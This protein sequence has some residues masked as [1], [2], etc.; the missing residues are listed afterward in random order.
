[1]HSRM[2]GAEVLG[3]EFATHRFAQVTVY[4]ARIDHVTV[5]LGVQVLEQVLT[6]Q[7]MTPPHDLHDALLI[8]DDLVPDTAF[9]SKLQDRASAAR[10]ADMPV[11]KR[12]DPETTVG[13]RIFGI[14]NARCR[15]TE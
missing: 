5:A 13:P 2:P 7:R 8:H 1:M 12:G 4:H 11:T 6:R 14:A 15:R 10:I 3:R 9:A